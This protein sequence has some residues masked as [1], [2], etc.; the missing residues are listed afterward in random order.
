MSAYTLAMR[1]FFVILGHTPW[2][3][4]ISL[5]G[6]LWLSWV[7]VRDA[8]NQLVLS[9]TLAAGESADVDGSRLMIVSAGI[10]LETSRKT[11]PSSPEG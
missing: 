9:R 1:M 7:E 2:I 10:R 3:L 4:L 11:P 6:A 5:L 8:K